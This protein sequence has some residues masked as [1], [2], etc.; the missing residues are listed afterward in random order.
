MVT[1]QRMTF[2]DLMATPDDGRRYELVRGGIL[3][4]PPPKGDHGDIEAAL[5][6]AIERYLHEQALRQGWL[7][8]QG[9]AARSRLAGRLVSG[10]AGIRFSLPDDREQ[11]RGIDAGYLSVEQ[12]A[13]LG[14]SSGNEYIAEVPALVAEVI[15]PSESSEYIEEKVADLLAG[16]A[17]LVW[18]LFPK[19]RSVRICLPDGSMRMV[20]ADGTLT[21]GEVLPGFSVALTSLFP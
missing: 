16:G 1:A 7:E 18:L 15:S 17:R 4:M 8:S 2:D 5:V 9:R 3:G 21:G 19:T 13:R 12:V 10:E 11:T 14:A 20:G 6:G